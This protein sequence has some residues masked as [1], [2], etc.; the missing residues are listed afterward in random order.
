MRE[1]EE[2]VIDCRY[3]NSGLGCRT[4]R[5]TGVLFGRGNVNPERK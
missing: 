2:R 1:S 4:D 5:R 3:Q